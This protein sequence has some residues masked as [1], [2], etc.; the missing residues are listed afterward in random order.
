MHCDKACADNYS[1]MKYRMNCLR[2]GEPDK[3]SIG[4]RPL[5]IIWYVTVTKYISCITSFCNS[6]MGVAG[7]DESMYLHA[8]C[9]HQDVLMNILQFPIHIDRKARTTTSYYIVLWSAVPIVHGYIQSKLRMILDY[10]CSLIIR[11]SMRCK[12]LISI[13][14]ACYW[15]PLSEFNH[16]SSEYDHCLEQQYLIAHIEPTALNI[17]CHWRYMATKIGV[18]IGSHNGLR[19]DGITPLPEPF[20]TYQI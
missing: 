20:L 4:S 18:N 11:T 16:N 17:S 5:L 12:L 1:H 19:P 10:S 8:I 2:W 9:I 15:C 14:P 3:W 6:D 13:I 7:G